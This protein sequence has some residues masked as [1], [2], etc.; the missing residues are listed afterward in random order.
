MRYCRN[1]RLL[2]ELA[3]D[4]AYV[5]TAGTDEWVILDGTAHAI[6]TQCHGAFTLDDLVAALAPR[7]PA[8]EPDNIRTDIRAFLGELVDRGILRV[9]HAD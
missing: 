3:E 8:A 7:Y 5:K 4:A 2:E 9:T 6:W 1:E